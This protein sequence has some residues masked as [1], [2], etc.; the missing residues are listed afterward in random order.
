MLDI[1]TAVQGGKFSQARKDKKGD[2]E[3]EQNKKKFWSVYLLHCILMLPS[4]HIYNI[5][6]FKEGNVAVPSAFQAELS[7]AVVF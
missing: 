7:G 4:C 5:E 6:W 3:K 2:D 1:K